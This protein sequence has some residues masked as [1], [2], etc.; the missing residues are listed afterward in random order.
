MFTKSLSI[1][2]YNVHIYEY[3][4]WHLLCLCMIT[5]WVTTKK[6]IKNCRSIFFSAW[7]IVCCKK[8]N[9][10]KLKERK[11]E[12][13]SELTMLWADFIMY[14]IF[15]SLIIFSFFSFDFFFFFWF[16]NSFFFFYFIG[17]SCLLFTS[18]R[19]LSS[20]HLPKTH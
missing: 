7:M 18:T 13:C 16:F 2:C 1:Q 12:N 6:K 4:A 19:F 14:F 17:R 3:C 15:V 20:C 10:K 9:K 11:H 8:K 5:S